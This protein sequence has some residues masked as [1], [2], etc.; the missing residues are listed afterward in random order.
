[1]KIGHIFEK[2][3]EKEKYNL[4]ILIL[5]FSPD[6]HIVSFPSP[7]ERVIL[8]LVVGYRAACTSDLVAQKNIDR[9]SS[10]SNSESFPPSSTDEAI[11]P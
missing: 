3:K 6:N 8:L 9:V 2:K 10:I 11:W 1:M 4:F 7:A 5:F